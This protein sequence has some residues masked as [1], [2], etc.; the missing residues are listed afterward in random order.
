MRH[1]KLKCLEVRLC[2]ATDT[3]VDPWLQ[4]NEFVTLNPFNVGLE[5]WIIGPRE[6]QGLESKPRRSPVLNFRLLH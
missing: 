2:L 6:R 3:M 1:S 4:I 5:A